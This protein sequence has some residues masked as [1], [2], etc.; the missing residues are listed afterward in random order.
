MPK[1]VLSVRESHDNQR[2]YH[3]HTEQLEILII[4]N[5]QRSITACSSF[6]ML[7]VDFVYE[8]QKK[9]Q[10]QYVYI[11]S[12]ILNPNMNKILVIQII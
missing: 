8:K 4:L 2:L 6:V 11:I 12:S 3:T 1:T 7:N 9:Q 5:K 10:Q